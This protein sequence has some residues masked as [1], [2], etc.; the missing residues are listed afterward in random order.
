MT[1]LSARAWDGQT[2]THRIQVMHFSASVSL[3]FS[4]GMAST[5]HSPAHTPQSVQS[6][7]ALGFMG[8]PP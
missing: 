8:T 5:G 3:G 2:V 1:G 7:P 6:R 4:L